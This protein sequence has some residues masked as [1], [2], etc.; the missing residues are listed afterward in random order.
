VFTP[1]ALLDVRSNRSHRGYWI[2]YRILSGVITALILLLNILTSEY[3]IDTFTE[4]LYNW[5]LIIHVN[6]TCS[7]EI[8]RSRRITRRSILSLYELR[9]IFV[10]DMLYTSFWLYARLLSRHFNFI[11]EASRVIVERYRLY[12]WRLFFFFSYHWRAKRTFSP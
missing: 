11:S 2:C 12:S 9:T 4:H 8:W 6:W 1:G 10:S 5:I 3:H 7:L